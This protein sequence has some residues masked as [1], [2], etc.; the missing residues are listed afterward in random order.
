MNHHEKGDDIACHIHILWQ[1]GC[2]SAINTAGNTEGVY[3][4]VVKLKRKIYGI[5]MNGVG[6]KKF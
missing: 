2:L 5:T 6:S 4:K 3:S 1:S